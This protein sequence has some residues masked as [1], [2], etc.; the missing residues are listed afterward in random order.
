[1]LAA[2]VHLSP[3]RLSH[4]FWQEM[5]LPIQKYIAWVRMKTAIDLVVHHDLNLVDA[6]YAAGFYDPSHLSQ[7][8]KDFF[9][10]RPSE[11]YNNSRI[12]QLTAEVFLPSSLVL[13]K[14]DS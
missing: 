7:H 2:V 5:G 11:V 8:F 9:G 14:V 1:M 4:V 10:I 3:G 13:K 12:V 6:A